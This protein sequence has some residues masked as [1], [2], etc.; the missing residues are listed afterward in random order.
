MSTIAEF[1]EKWE[2]RRSV[3]YCDFC[4]KPWMECMKRR[5]TWYRS[6]WP[7]LDHGLDDQA[8][9]DEAMR[10]AGICLG[11]NLSCGVGRALNKRPLSEEAI[12][13]LCDEDAKD[14]FVICARTF[15]E[16]EFD[17]VRWYALLSL[18]HLLGSFSKWPKFVAAVK[19]ED[20]EAAAGELKWSGRRC[21]ICDGSG[22]RPIPKGTIGLTE[23]L[24]RD[25]PAC[26]R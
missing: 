8:W 5:E 2:G 9:V 19:A 11:G 1:L 14:D 3:P 23:P 20:W 22:N 13:F 18:A 26:S 6:C 25:C 17:G 4:G 16:Q 7:E 21:E 15:G 10:E 24:R 12:A